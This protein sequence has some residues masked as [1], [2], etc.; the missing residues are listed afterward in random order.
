LVLHVDALLVFDD[1]D[2]VIWVVSFILETTQ[3]LHIDF[4]LSILIMSLHTVQPQF[5]SI[6]KGNEFFCK[7]IFVV[8]NVV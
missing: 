8:T 1:Y 3:L 7:A 5:F 4:F 6:F 2:L